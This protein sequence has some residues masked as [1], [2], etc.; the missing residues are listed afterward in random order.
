MKGGVA[1]AYCQKANQEHEAFMLYDMQL[2]ASNEYL[3]ENLEI[4]MIT[5]RKKR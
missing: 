2:L 1:V 5:N 3:W 4:N